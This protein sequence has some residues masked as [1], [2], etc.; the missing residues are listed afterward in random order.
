MFHKQSLFVDFLTT[1]RIDNLVMAGLL[2]CTDESIRQNF[3]TTLLQLARTLTTA[4][5]Q[6]ESAL[7]FLLKLLSKNFH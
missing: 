7:G 2:Y 1:D 3:Q 6:T 5:S 4:S